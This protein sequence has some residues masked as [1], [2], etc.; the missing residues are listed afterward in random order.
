MEQV[1]YTIGFARKKA[2]DFF[3][4]LKRNGIEVVLDIRLHNT[5]QLAGFAKY[6]D[7]EYFLHEIG[8]MGYVHDTQFSPTKATLKR[9]KQKEIPWEQYVVE[10]NQTMSERNILEHIKANYSPDVKYCL[11]CS[12]PKAEHCHRMLVSN[13]FK[14]VF[15]NLEIIHL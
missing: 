9:Y 10:F 11:L 2:E 4:L 7:I 8:N 15:H 12:E 13:I 5:S 14:K 1:I 6:P 3:E